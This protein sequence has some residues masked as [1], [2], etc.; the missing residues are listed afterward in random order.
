MPREKSKKDVQNTSKGNGQITM[1]ESEIYHSNRESYFQGKR[2]LEIP[3]ENFYHDFDKQTN[4][5]KS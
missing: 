3:E 2:T 5:P 1:T 4:L